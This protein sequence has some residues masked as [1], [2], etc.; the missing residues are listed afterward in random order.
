MIGIFDSGVGGLASAEILQ[1]IF[2]N[3][4]IV[5]LADR[6]HAPYGT[7]TK[8]ELISLATK[9][10]LRLKSY[11]ARLILIACCTASTVYPYLDKELRD[12]SMPII[13][14]A[15]KIAAK[16]Q[17]I[18]VIATEYTVK[19]AAFSKEIS[20]FSDS[21]V[22]EIPASELVTIVEGGERDGLITEKGKNA[23]FAVSE[24]I[25]KAFPDTLVLGCTHF[26]HLKKSFQAFLPDVRIVNAAEE[27][28]LALCSEILPEAHER[29]VCIYTE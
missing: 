25:K 24:K 19:S 20:R 1:K 28:A 14:P 11:G 27:G 8:E 13:T 23:V 6:K 10:I 22:F 26:S 12:I 29:G 7:K 21:K 4:D 5:Y 17:R 9:D 16:G 15:S 3:E 18:A 2:K